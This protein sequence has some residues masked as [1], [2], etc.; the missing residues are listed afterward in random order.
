MKKTSVITEI[1]KLFGMI[2]V[3]W[4]LWLFVFAIVMTPE[5]A[6]LVV[7]PFKGASLLMGTLTG[8]LICLGLKYNAIHKAR[9]ETKAAF[10]NICIFEERAEKLFDKANRVADKYMQFEENVQVQI[11]HERGSV[12]KGKRISNAKQFQSALEGYPNLKANESIMELLNQIKDCENRLANQK[13]TYNQTVERYNT[14]IHS[15]PATLFRKICHF[16]DA[17]FYT[18]ADDNMISD[19]E[20]GI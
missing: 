9:Q 3:G 8:C 20:L 10:S 11:A 19:E 6:D 17:E 14:L 2:I 15:F 1:L 18:H 5:E 13:V 7:E 16:E 12:M 4:I